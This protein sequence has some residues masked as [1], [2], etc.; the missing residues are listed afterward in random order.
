MNT[1]TFLYEMTCTYKYFLIYVYVYIVLCIRGM[2]R[3]R[4]VGSIKLHVS[5]A[6]ESYKKDYIL[7][8]RPIILSILLTVVTPYLRV[9]RTVGDGVCIYAYIFIDKSSY[10][11]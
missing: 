10:I 2:G 7:Q 9:V 1:C 11:Y 8:K 5:F 6:K 4:L 3:V